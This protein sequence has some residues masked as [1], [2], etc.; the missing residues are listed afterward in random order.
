MALKQAHF[1]V[2]SDMLNAAKLL[3]ASDGVSY[4]ELMRQVIESYLAYRLYDE[5]MEG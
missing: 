1:M 3:A 2:D 5:C 4:A